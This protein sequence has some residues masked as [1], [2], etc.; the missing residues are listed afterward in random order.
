MKLNFDA[1]ELK[2]DCGTITI[3]PDNECKKMVVEMDGEKFTV[4][5]WVASPILKLGAVIDEF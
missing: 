2:M 1:V 4:P 5:Y 3:T